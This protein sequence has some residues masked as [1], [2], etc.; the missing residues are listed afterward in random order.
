MAF[1]V[2]HKCA[3]KF[4]DESSYECW[5]KDIDIWCELTD[6]DVKKRA[7]AIHLS[8][9]GRARIASS[10]LEV[11]D[12]KKDNGVNI[13][14]AKLDGIFLAEKGRRQFAVFHD[15]YNLRR[16]EEVNIND[17][18]TEFEHA[19]FKFGREDMTLPDAV[20]AFML[21]SACN[22]GDSD[23]QLVMSAITDATYGHMKAALKR[24]YG[25]NASGTITKPQVEIKVEPVFETVSETE[26]AFFTRNNRRGRGAFRGNRQSRGQG[27]RKFSQTLNATNRKMNPSGP[28]GD[29]SR[30]LICDSKFHWAR[31]CP[32]AY[33]NAY[34]TPKPDEEEHD[35]VYLSLF[36]GLTDNVEEENKVR[37]LVSEA[38]ECA[39]LDT[40]CALTVCGQSWLS[41]YLESLSEFERSKIIE[42]SSAATFTFGDGKSF[43]SLKKLVIPCWIGKQ[44]AYITTNVVE[45]NIPLLMSATSMKRAD[46]LWDFKNDSVMVRGSKI[47]LRRSLSGHFL[48]PLSM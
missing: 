24:I 16:K 31:N 30:C 26:P 45:C 1:S 17:F 15:L 3:S 19:Y 41:D 5:K 47:K 14:L 42:S 28:D 10:E 13:L 32:H 4:D 35:N 39:V 18:V 36:M 9:T 22:L 25:I 29:I 34:K 27:A 23:V 37:K 7:L 33:E 8:L 11:S 44:R 46:M 21:L 2:S 6:L 38:K 12:L 40:G 48:L 43:P 20:K